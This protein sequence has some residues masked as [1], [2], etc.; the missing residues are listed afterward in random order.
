MTDFIIHL[1]QY[2]QLPEESQGKLRE[3]LQVVRLPK[4]HHLFQAGRVERYIYFIRKGLA[5]AFC[6]K[7]GKEVT[8]WFGMEGDVLLSYYSYTAGKPGYEDVELLEDSELYQL[9]LQ[10]LQNLYKTDIAIAN[11][12]RKLAESELV[13]TEER[14]IAQKFKTA[15]ER[16]QDLLDQY[17]QLLQRVQLGHIASFLNISQVTLSRIRSGRK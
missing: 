9:S 4:G 5:R 10:S 16:Y 15:A 2:Y 12:G 17:P 13:K 3:L 14:L 11:L 7:Q 8:F 6:L 1:Q